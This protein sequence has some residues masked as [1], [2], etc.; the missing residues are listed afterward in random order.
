MNLALDFGNTFAKA[1]L[2]EGSMLQKVITDVKLDHLPDIVGTYAPDNII[3]SSVSVKPSDIV[4]R[5]GGEGA[6]ILRHDI[7]LPFKIAYKTPDTLGLDRIAAVAGAQEMLPGANCL[8]IDTGT[9]FTY[10]LLD[11]QGIYH[12]G[13]I[14]PGIKMRFQALHT[15]TANLPLINFEEET[16]LIGQSTKGSILSGVVNGTIAEI[17]EIIRQYCDK[18]ADLQ[19]IMCGGDA[20]F[21]ENRLKASIFAAP[22]LVLR[23]LNRILLYN[24]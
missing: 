18:F 11:S 20:K 24:V 6:L 1:G 2:F 12:G 4:S 19:I 23:G 5:L 7:P 8:V 16:P 17:T 22:E 13:G 9:C 14:S 10:D 21:F 3:I 15:F